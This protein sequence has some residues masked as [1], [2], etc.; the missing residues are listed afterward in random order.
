MAT[1]TKKMPDAMPDAVGEG[2]NPF[3]VPDPNR[4]YAN[5]GIS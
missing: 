5:E 3:A 4:I 1:K 2:D